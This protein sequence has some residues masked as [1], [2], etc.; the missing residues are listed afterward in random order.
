MLKLMDKKYLQFY[1]QIFCLS[2]PVPLRTVKNS[3]RPAVYEELVVASGQ[4]DFFSPGCNIL[5][6]SNILTHKPFSFCILHVCTLLFF[7]VYSSWAQYVSIL[8]V[9]AGEYDTMPLVW[10]NPSE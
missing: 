9:W 1:A 6:G 5:S 10:N 7:F 8:C 2:K 3:T 4:E